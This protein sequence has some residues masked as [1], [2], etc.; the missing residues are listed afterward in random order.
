MIPL[1][2]SID[3]LNIIHLFAKKLYIVYCIHYTN[4][5]HCIN[6]KKN[7]FFSWIQKQ[8]TNSDLIATIQKI[9]NKSVINVSASP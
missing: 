2:F 1:S 7:N 9:S 5:H 8:D 6:N 4:N 3:L